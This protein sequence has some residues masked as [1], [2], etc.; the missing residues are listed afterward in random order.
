MTQKIW[1][2]P[3]ASG[4]FDLVYLQ[5]SSSVRLTISLSTR[6][7]NFTLGLKRYTFTP[8]YIIYY[9]STP[10][11]S[12]KFSFQTKPDKLHRSANSYFRYKCE[13]VI[14]TSWG[15]LCPSEARV[16]RPYEDKITFSPLY[17]T[18]FF[19]TTCGKLNVGRASLFERARKRASRARRKNIHP[20]FYH[21]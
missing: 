9:I 1:C 10:T 2:A 21:L 14:L 8:R 17:R 20:I 13:I 15:R 12:R 7:A 11:C 5:Y 18:L 19:H 16:K 4:P 3:S 6:T